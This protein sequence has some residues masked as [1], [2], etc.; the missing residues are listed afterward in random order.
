MKT[1]LITGATDGIGKQTAIKLSELDVKIII[2][3]REQNRIDAVIKEIKET[4]GNQNIES[5]LS[6]F[7]DLEQVA[8]MCEKIKQ[9]NST[10][11]ILFNNAAVISLEKEKTIDGFEK[12]FQTN[13]L[14]GFLLTEK[15]SPLIEA[16]GNAGIIN[17]SSMIHAVDIDF[18]NLQGEKSYNGSKNYAL[19]KLCNII[20][21]YSLS[22]KYKG[23]GISANAMH[24]GVINTKLL[25]TAFSGGLPVEEGA[26]T[27]YYLATENIAIQL[28][29]QYFENNRPMQSN[30]VSYKEDI[31]DKLWEYSMK[32]IKKYL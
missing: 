9:T 32:L 2:H 7:E 24:P 1:I 26:K 3:G 15:L 28:T 27:M 6:D 31:Q 13:H 18:E 21:A 5:A 16:A 25:N 29:G 20:H 4:N 19:S 23:K 17:V 10:I 14:A 30:P 8:Q 11:D 22:R 12:T